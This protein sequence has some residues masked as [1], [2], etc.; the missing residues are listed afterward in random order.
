[1]NAS[2]DERNL[3]MIAHGLVVLTGVTTVLSALGAIGWLASIASVVLYFV[4]KSKGPFVTRHAKQAAGLQVCLFLV[5]IVLAIFTS[6]FSVGALAAGSIGGA[7]ALG[8]LMVIIA[9]AIGVAATVFGI[10]GL[11][12]AQKGEAYTYPLVGKLI[13]GINL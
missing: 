10:M 12:R 3:G 11:L 7:L 4:W 13:D 8:G 1:M 5:G 2:Q 9:L 6:I